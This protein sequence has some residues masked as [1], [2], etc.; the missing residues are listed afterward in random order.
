VKPADPIGRVALAFARFGTSVENCTQRMEKAASSF[1]GSSDELR[2][3][4]IS[5]FS[6]A[7]PLVM[8]D[9]GWIRVGAFAASLAI[10]TS[11]GSY[12]A[13][14][15]GKEAQDGSTA[16]AAAT[17]Q[18]AFHDGSAGGQWLAGVAM[19]NDLNKLAQSC[20]DHSH[21]EA[22]GVAC[23]IALWSKAPVATRQ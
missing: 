2:R 8:R 22:G 20:A 9:L 14:Q 13:F 5:F 15:A 18:A 1:P 3:C 23:S 17:L 12:L 16:Y 7:K 4:F 19:N 11:L 21:P 10:C 6:D